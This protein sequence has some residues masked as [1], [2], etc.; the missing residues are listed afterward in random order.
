MVAMACGDLNN[1]V[2]R[3]K[4]VIRQIRYDADLDN[5]G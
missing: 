1:N 5:E 4:T 2:Q 3:L